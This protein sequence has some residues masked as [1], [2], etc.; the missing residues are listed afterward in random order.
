MV[1]CWWSEGVVGQSHGV[2]DVLGRDIGVLVLGRR[3]AAA[4]RSTGRRDA[5]VTLSRYQTAAH[6]W[7]VGEAMRWVC[8]RSS[9]GVRYIWVRCWE[10]RAG[11][12]VVLML[13]LRTIGGVAVAIVFARCLRCLH[14][15]A[16]LDHVG[17][18]GDGSWAAVEFEEEAAGVAE[19]G[20]GLI[21]APEGC[22]R[23]GTVLTNGLRSSSVSYCI[24]LI[25]LVLVE[26]IAFGEI[27]I[28]QSIWAITRV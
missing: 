3:A 28:T 8:Y 20:S 4:E 22:R 5:V 19:D 18:E 24:S 14:A 25:V 10:A 17:L 26:V 11:L 6:L 1:G 16:R 2:E 12:G 13:V 21:A 7:R 15:V 23:G 27:S 9:V